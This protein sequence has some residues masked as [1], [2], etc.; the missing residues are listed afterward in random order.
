MNDDSRPEAAKSRAF[1]FEEDDRYTVAARAERVAILNRLCND[2]TLLSVHPDG[3]ADFILT[4]LVMVDAEQGILVFEAGR[5]TV[6]NDRL[7]RAVRITFVTELDGIRVQFK[8]GAALPVLY[9]PDPAF[10]IDI[11]NSIVRRQRREYFRI[12]PPLNRPILVQVKLSE[13]PETPTLP[14]RGVDISCGGIV[15]LVEGELG[16]IEVGQVLPEVSITLPGIA[17][18]KTGLEVRNKSVSGRAGRDGT[19]RVGCRFIGLSQAN[20]ARIQRY[21]NHLEVERRSRA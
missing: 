4:T 11:P 12:A 6:T 8:S 5:N 1:E 15:L 9:G 7:E 21:I 13:S 19:T 3:G 18:L 20:S 10:Q 16:E 14:A 2:A 17:T